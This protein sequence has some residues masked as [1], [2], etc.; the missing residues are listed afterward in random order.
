MN[1]G[2]PCP[3]PTCSQVF[4][5]QAVKG[6]ASLKCPRC[7]T[8]FQFRSVPEAP[9]PKRRAERPVASR[10][11]ENPQTPAPVSSPAGP[12]GFPGD[13]PF[14]LPAEAVLPRKRRRSRTRKEWVK[15][16]IA[17]V[18]VV[19]LAGAA[20]LWLKNSVLPWYQQQLAYD[21][22]PAPS[23]N[24]NSPTLNCQ[25]A[26]PG[27]AWREDATARIW[28]GASVVA[29]R[30]TD[31]SGWLN[32]AAVDYKTRNPRDGEL[33]D[34]AIQQLGA[35]FKNFGW[36]Q[37]P[38]DE[39]AGQRAQHLAFQGDANQVLVQGD[40]YAFAARGIA[41]WLVLWAPAKSAPATREEFEEL[42]RGFSLLKERE[43]WEERR[44]PVVVYEGAR[45]R[46]WL[47]DTAGLWEE[48][49]QPK[50]ADPQADLLL[51]A[52]DN[53]QAKDDRMARVLA[54]LL[55]KQPDLPVAV[56]AARAHVA[57]QQR[58][59][60]KETVID[61]VLDAAGPQDRDE[62]V[63]EVSGH[64]VKLHVKNTK[65][66]E[67]FVVLAVVQ[68]AENDLAIECECD[69]KRRSLWEADFKQLLSTLSLKSPRE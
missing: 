48:W 36:S 28:G 61:V 46:Y 38:D 33:F 23:P 21:N 3:N 60:Y 17:A 57:A 39:V 4:P 22:T 8:L 55:K 9:V 7:G 32:L 42:R 63:G 34:G 53:A 43:T 50:D 24:V 30:R 51:Q 26:L 49:R 5:P 47:R 11:T 54:L 64:I 52:R 58:E 13:D 19:G 16:A 68:L 65:V 37:K 10:P 1:S 59:Q 6:Q 62:A 67:R 45:A 25:F 41:Y 35:F 12:E 31:P 69:W 66:R 40:C 56:K 14:A 15:I 44:P 29:L 20:G 27:K 2:F 18:L